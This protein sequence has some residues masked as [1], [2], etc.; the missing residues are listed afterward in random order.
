MI[1]PH[2]IPSP[3]MTPDTL[4]KVINFVIF[5]CIW[6]ACVLGGNEYLALS[7]ALIALHFT[8]SGYRIRDLKILATVTILGGACDLTLSLTGVL[9]FD[10]PF[11]PAW[12]LILWSGFSLTLTHSLAWLGSAHKSLQST[13]GAL[14]GSASYFAGYKLGAVSFTYDTLPTLG[15]IFIQWGSL[16]PIFY[17]MVNRYARA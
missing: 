9:V 7:I 1:R 12:L 15:I 14:G 13:L 3:I 5:Q 8:L 11:I 6:F 17:F 2:D 10:T 4:L 16:I